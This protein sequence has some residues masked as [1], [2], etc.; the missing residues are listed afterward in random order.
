MELSP[1]GKAASIA[2]PALFYVVAAD[3]IAVSR[4]QCICAEA[5]AAAGACARSFACSHCRL[6][7]LDAHGCA[8][9]SVPC[10]AAALSRG[11]RRRR[12][13]K[14]EKEA[15]QRASRPFFLALIR[16]VRLCAY[17]AL[18]RNNANS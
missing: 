1:I 5:A 18:G 7:H 6:V 8:V 10:P 9:Q 3:R 4:R 13:R 11:C 12:C 2:V 14:T 15:K 16:H 17:F